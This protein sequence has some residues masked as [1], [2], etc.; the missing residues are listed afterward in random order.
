MK[1][2]STPAP[3]TGFVALSSS[4]E[5]VNRAGSFF[6][7]KPDAEEPTLGVWAGPAQAD[8]AGNIDRGFLLTFGDFALTELT[9]AITLRLSCDSLRA[10]PVGNWIEARVRR[11]PSDSGAL[12]FAEAM[13]V[14]SD[15]TQLM[16]VHGAFLPFSKRVSGRH[17]SVT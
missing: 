5:F 16:R 8:T 10:Y 6:I 12:V 3:P 4:C 11:L 17:G 13:I 1:F 14:S 15:G 2:L 9:Q 7:R